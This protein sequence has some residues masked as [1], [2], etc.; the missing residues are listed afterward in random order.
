[1]KKSSI[2]N[3][4]TKKHIYII[5]FLYFIISTIIFRIAANLWI[6]IAASSI[7][8]T[9]T[10][11][12]SYLHN[13]NDKFADIAKIIIAVIGLSISFELVFKDIDSFTIT[14]LTILVLIIHKVSNP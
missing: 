11:I 4:N 1:M 9:T 3:M 12:T 2:C 14:C 7:L 6:S 10:I 8:I 5:Y 13:L